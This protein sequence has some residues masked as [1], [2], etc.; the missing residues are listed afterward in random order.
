LQ[1]RQIGGFFTLQNPTYVDSREAMGFCAVVT[2]AHQTSTMHIFAGRIVRRYPILLCEAN[3][4]FSP[5]IER[6]VD[7]DQKRANAFPMGGGER[8]AYFSFGTRI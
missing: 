2:I 7:I 5:P 6:C 1:D 8:G 3:D 4:L